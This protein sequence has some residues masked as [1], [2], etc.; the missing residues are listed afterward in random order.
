MLAGRRILLGV[1]GGIAAYKAAYLARRLVEQGAEVRVVMTQS[2]TAFLG[3]QTLAGISG[4][5][6]TDRLFGGQHQIPHTELGQWAELVVVAPATAN[7]IAKLANGIADE[8]L[9][10]TLLATRAPIVLAPAMHI[11]MW[12][13]PSVQR[14]LER[15]RADG[16]TIV[17][18]DSG[19]LA[20]GDE[21]TGR[22]AEPDEIIAV[23]EVGS[24]SDL[25]GWS[26]LVTAGGTREPIDPV[27]FIGNR[28]SGKMGYSLAREAARRGAAVTLVS[29]ASQPAPPG[30]Q[31]VEVETAEQMAQSVLSRAG[32]CDVVVMAAAVADFR[33]KHAE[34]QK[35]SRG[36]GPPEMTLEPTSDILAELAA[37]PRR[38]FLVGFAAET[39]GIHRALVK[40]TSKG[41]DLTVANDVTL[42]GSEF[43]SDTSLVTLILPDGNREAWPLLPKR[44]VASRLW[45]RIRTMRSGA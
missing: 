41:V 11:E 16:H 10:T 20:G 24:Q 44:E 21:G 38:P 18:P 19:S 15:L 45:D 32:E 14:N 39:G 35:L 34:S 42:P 3:A 29:A 4:H 17:G 8:I 2:A 43:G 26:V 7:L 27:R 28:S 31:L 6:V 13:Q 37:L 12:E 1:S 9:S 23:L 40:A 33:P 30:T 25:S 22:M 36:D 5:P